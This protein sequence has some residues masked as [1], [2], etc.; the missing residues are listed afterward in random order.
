MA[1]EDVHQLYKE[2]SREVNSLS[3]DLVKGLGALRYASETNRGSVEELKAEIRDLREKLAEVKELAAATEVRLK[4]LEEAKREHTGK[5][6]TLKQKEAHTS[7]AHAQNQ[8]RTKGQWQL[9]AALGTGFVA[10]LS[11]IIQAVLSH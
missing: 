1:R 7:A 8:E 5:I 4:A 10:L 11:S 9:W 2:V 3:N 6:D